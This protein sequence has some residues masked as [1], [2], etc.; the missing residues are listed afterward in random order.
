[1][2]KTT[3]F[4]LL[5]ISLSANAYFLYQIYDIEP[6]AD[7]EQEPMGDIVE[8]P[9]PGTYP[10]I[11]VIDGNTVAIGYSGRT[12][13]V[14]LLGIRVPEPNVPGGPE[15]HASEAT[16]HL[17]TLTQTGT[18][19]LLF[20]PSVGPRDNLG[21]LLAYIELP[22]GTDVAESMLRDGFAREYSEPEEH[23]RIVRYRAAE[24]SAIENE[25]GLWNTTL[26][27]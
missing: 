26:C 3:L 13:H 20:D 21:R 18:V 2:T 14:R 11:R 9:T 5:A 19:V 8:A 23:E 12:E 10:F 1:M 17:R 22:D 16:K 27:P 7:A 15:C 25:V 24:A 6:A 4:I